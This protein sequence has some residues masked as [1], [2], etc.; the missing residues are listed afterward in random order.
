MAWF[1]EQVQFEQARLR[2]F[3]RSLGVRSEAVDDVSQEVLV[4][5]LERLDEFDRDGDFGAW[6]RQI[7]RRVIANERRKE[8]RRSRILSDRVTD[9]LLELGD[10]STC[11]RERQEHMEEVTALRECLAELPKHGRELLQQRYFNDLSPGAIAGLMG[12]SSNQVRQTLLRLRRALLGCIERR[13][14]TELA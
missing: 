4:I 11:P 2:A 13:M 6:V 14:G 7:A 1:M 3:I 9:L 10:D 12:R 5:S 8:S